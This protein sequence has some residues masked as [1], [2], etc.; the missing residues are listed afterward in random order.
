M[1]TLALRPLRLKKDATSSSVSAARTYFADGANRD[2]V[3]SSAANKKCRLALDFAMDSLPPWISC[4]RKVAKTPSPQPADHLSSPVELW[5]VVT[6]TGVS[7]TSS[8]LAPLTR[9]LNDG[10]S[11]SSGMTGVKVLRGLSG[12][13]RLVMMLPSLTDEGCMSMDETTK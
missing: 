11:L 6:V 12:R 8:L 9:L 1:Y 3:I 2:V 10:L 5:A 13:F 4:C 7:A